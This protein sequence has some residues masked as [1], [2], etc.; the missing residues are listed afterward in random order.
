MKKI[1]ILALL[2]LC[3]SLNAENIL[4]GTYTCEI[5]V[6]D[7]TIYSIMHFSENNK[8]WEITGMPSI[9]SF[10]EDS[11]FIIVQFGKYYIENNKLITETR[12][13]H[14]IE[15]GYLGAYNSD[16]F[17]KIVEYGLEI[18]DND[19][20]LLVLEK[21]KTDREHFYEKLQ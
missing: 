13:Y 11:L 2:F 20:I 10:K 8:Y 3:N 5:P 18:I 4:R 9:S 7:D 21:R 19:E 14:K 6:I 1:S 12:G 16:G 15:P 17:I